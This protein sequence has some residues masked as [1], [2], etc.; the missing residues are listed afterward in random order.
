MRFGSNNWAIVWAGV[1][2]IG[3]KDGENGQVDTMRIMYPI[4]ARGKYPAYPRGYIVYE[5]REEPTAQ[6]VDPY[7]GRTLSNAEKHFSL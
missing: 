4:P 6:G 3:G 7:T 5:N 2:F 1:K